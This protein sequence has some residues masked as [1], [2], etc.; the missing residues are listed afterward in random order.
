MK[1]PSFLKPGDRIGIVAPARKVTHGEMSAGMEIL[2][3]WGFVPVEGKYLYGSFNQ[4]SGTDA[5][6]ASDFQEMMDDPQIKAIITARGGY[7]CMKIIDLL[8]FEKFVKQPK[9]IAG[10]SDFTVF[11]SHLH[12]QYQIQSIHSIMLFNMNPDRFDMVAVE[13]LGKALTGLE[14]NYAYEGKAYK[15]LQRDGKCYGSVVGGN[16]SLLYALSKS[17][18]DI[19]TNGKILFIEDLDEYLYHVDRMIIQLKRAGKLSGLA[20]LIVGGMND[21]RDN[22][23][24]FGKSAE[25]I[26]REAV[27]EYDYPV[28]FDF[29]AGHQKDNRALIFGAQ[30]ELN[31]GSNVSL[32]YLNNG[33]A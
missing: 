9:W 33:C 31:V 32:N 26:I 1:Q 20:G 5:E 28:C 22:E 17:A 11:H 25:E 7:G 15:S 30:A 19:D 27:D 10:F 14:T 8:N 29:P 4:F 13:S 23:T 12:R 16:L 21:M 18:S 3:G 24:K 6:R 2:K